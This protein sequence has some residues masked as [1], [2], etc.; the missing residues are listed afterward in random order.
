MEK[1]CPSCGET[2]P[3]GGSNCPKCGASMP[4]GG[5]PPVQRTRCG[6]C[7]A[8]IPT[9]VGHCSNCGYGGG[10]QAVP[11]RGGSM[12]ERVILTVLFVVIGIP[13]GLFG[14]C[15]GLFA[16]SGS[17]DMILLSLGSLVI[18]GLLLWLWIRALR[19]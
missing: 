8:E 10:S 2:V 4:V 1:K 18:C 12:A 3:V 19:R 6:N 9:G 16:A 14:A 11:K 17:P 15:A 13:A 7:G 5:A